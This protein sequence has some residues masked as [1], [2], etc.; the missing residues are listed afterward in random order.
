[1]FICAHF[2][3]VQ[4]ITVARGQK[5]CILE[6]VTVHTVTEEKA[7]GQANRQTDT[8]IYIQTHTHKVHE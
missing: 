3:G 6:L 1:M 2:N 7:N 8:H 5:I 4:L